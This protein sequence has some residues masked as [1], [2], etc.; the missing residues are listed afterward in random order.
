M[1]RSGEEYLDS[2]RDGREVWVSGQ[3][4]DDVTTHPALGPVIRTR[5]ELYD[6]AQEEAKQAGTDAVL[7][8]VHPDSGEPET[9]LFKR[10]LE[11]TDWYAKWR[12]NDMISAEVG[13]LFSRLGDDNVGELWSLLDERPKIEPLEKTFTDNIERHLRRVERED[14][15]HVSGNTDP[16]GDRSK[17]PQDQDPDMLLRV[18]RETDNGIVVRGAKYETASAYA[19]QAFI[20]PTI[21]NWGDAKL[22]PY[23]AGF[24]VDMNAKGL[25]HIC[26]SL[27]AES[28][29]PRDY[30]MSSR[31]DEIEAL[32]IFDDVEVPWENVFFYD[33]TEAATIVRSS[34]HRY[35]AFSMLLRLVTNAELLI[36]VAYLNAEQ[37]G[38]QRQ[39]AVQEKLSQLVAYRESIRAHL[40]ASIESAEPSAGGLMTPQQSILFSG[41]YLAV[42]Q[43][44]EMMHIARELSG[45]QICLTPDAAS[46][47]A[48]ELAPY[49]EK[50][51]RLSGR[52]TPANRRRLL[53]Y[54]K[55]L[56]NS[57]YA[58][59][60]LTFQLFSQAPPFAHLASIF[61]SFDF[62]PATDLTIRSAG[63]DEG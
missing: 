56:L 15:F 1:I 33:N 46:F 53:A 29:D 36:G 12:A 54:A 19:N 35:A 49:L 27:N 57:G 2:I 44:P 39:Q 45:G 58:G 23:A 24:I 20:K 16:K 42:K 3:R 4:V 21:S 52:W 60:K 43:L 5:A 18:V 32:L 40:I 22:S 41:R 28:P 8:H 50:Y 13:G 47:A 51:Y 7:S 11:K 61:H 38:L 26:R 59:H 34:L 55:D 37:T 9:I 31:L 10:P 62:T 30:P 63:I 6:L 17:R 48:P 14:I 25:K